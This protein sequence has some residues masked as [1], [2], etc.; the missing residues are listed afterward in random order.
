MS[1]PVVSCH[2]PFLPCLPS[3][4]LS[5][6]TSL[7]ACGEEEKEE[8]E[9]ALCLYGMVVTA[10]VWR[11]RR[12]EAVWWTTPV[13]PSHHLTYM[14]VAGCLPCLLPACPTWVTLP[15]YIPSSGFSCLT[16]SSLFAVMAATAGKKNGV[17]VWWKEGRRREGR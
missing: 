2:L 13:M 8:E 11:W 6:A 14:P 17:V 7:P 3:L 12:L 16:F 15:T 10:V 4:H 5:P 1:L 9:G